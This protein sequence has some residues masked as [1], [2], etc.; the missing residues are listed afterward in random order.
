MRSLPA[1]LILTATLGSLIACA[2][3]TST[4][5]TTAADVPTREAEEARASRAPIGGVA[6]EG[7]LACRAH[8]LFDGDVELY[9]DWKGTEAHGQLLRE[10]PSGMVTTTNVRA[11]RHKGMVIA[12]DTLSQDLVVHAATLREKNGKTYIRLGDARAPWTACE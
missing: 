11:E 10:A 5:T 2:P 8:N 6:P 9:L 7:Q 4:T 3:A 12:D 1:C